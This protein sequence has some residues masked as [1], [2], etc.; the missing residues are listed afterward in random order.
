L[1]QGNADLINQL[2]N[3]PQLSSQK[4][5]IEA[6]NDLELL[7]RYLTLLNITDKVESFHF[8]ENIR[9]DLS[10]GDI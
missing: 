1:I 7:F 4:L 5:A 6:L 10:L 2:R 8:K 3:N 9:I